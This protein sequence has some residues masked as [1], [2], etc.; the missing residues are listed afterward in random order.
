MLFG[1]VMLVTLVP[2]NARLAIPT[3]GKPSI[4]AGTVTAPPEPQY[5]LIVMPPFW[6]V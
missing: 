3:T 1:I 2:E 5:R 4:A 6:L